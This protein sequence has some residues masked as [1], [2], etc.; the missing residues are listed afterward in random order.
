VEMSRVFVG[1]SVYPT[2]DG[3]LKR[4]KRGL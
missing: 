2:L 4:G 1:E 3:R